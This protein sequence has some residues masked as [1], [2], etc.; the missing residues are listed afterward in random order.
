[1]LTHRNAIMVTDSESDATA[2]QQVEPNGRH[3]RASG[4]G[5][6]AA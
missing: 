3:L 2:R 6:I 4:F 5:R 1:M